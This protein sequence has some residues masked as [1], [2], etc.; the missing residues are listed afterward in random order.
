MSQLYNFKNMRIVFSETYMVTIA[1]KY[2]RK[3]LRKEKPHLP[4]LYLRPFFLFLLILPSQ[5]SFISE[6]SSFLEINL[7][8]INQLDIVNCPK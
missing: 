1:I 2:I 5:I 7:Y 3:V 4:L 8:M 6:L